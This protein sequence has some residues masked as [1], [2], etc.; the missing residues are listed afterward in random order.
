MMNGLEVR[1]PFLDLEVADFA[2]RLPHRFKLRG[3]TTKYLLKLAAKPFLPEVIV[4][5]KK[6][7]FGSPVGTWLHSGRLAPQPVTRLIRE[8]LAAHLAGQADER[9]FL[10]CEFVWQEWQKNR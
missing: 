5:R 9:Q 8:K 3:K 2:R 4:Q 10:W 1:S 7:G 6:K